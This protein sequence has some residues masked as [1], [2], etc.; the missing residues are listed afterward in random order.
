MSYL[1]P[2]HGLS[3][4]HNKSYENDGNTTTRTQLNQAINFRICKKVQPTCYSQ[5]N[6]DIQ[7]SLFIFWKFSSFLRIFSI[8]LAFFIPASRA[9]SCCHRGERCFGFVRAAPCVASDYFLIHVF[10]R[11]LLN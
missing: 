6:K 1:S 10:A 11:E 7:Y 9:V 5:C 3:K 4:P 2:K 8:R